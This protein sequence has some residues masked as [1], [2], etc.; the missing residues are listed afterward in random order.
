LLTPLE[1]R[2]KTKKDGPRNSRRGP[3]CVLGGLRLL[4]QKDLMSLGK[5]GENLR[6]RNRGVEE[7]KGFVVHGKEGSP[8]RTEKKGGEES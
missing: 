2:Q 7:K 4:H 8:V 1:K 3:L 6:G 5:E